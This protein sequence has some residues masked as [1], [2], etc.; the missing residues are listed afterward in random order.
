MIIDNF[1]MYKIHHCHC[2][3]YIINIT[4]SYFRE[5]VVLHVFGSEWLSFA[6]KCIVLACASNS[7]LYETVQ[8]VKYKQLKLRRDFKTYTID[9]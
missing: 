2:K 5:K 4:V 6:Y 7:I 1:Y 8:A 3:I 9:Q